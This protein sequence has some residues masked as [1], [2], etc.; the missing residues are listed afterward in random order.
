M[1]RRINKLTNSK[2]GRITRFISMLHPKNVD[3]IGSEFNFKYGDRERFQTGVGGFLTLLVVIVT[4]GAFYSTVQSLIIDPK[5]EVSVS[6]K[7]SNR[8]PRYNLYNESITLGLAFVDPLVGVQFPQNAPKYMTIKAY[9]ENLN[10]DANTALPLRRRV[11][12][13]KYKPCSQVKDKKALEPFLKHKQSKEL[14]MTF[15]FCPELDGIS[16]RYFIESKF[17][18]P[19]LYELFVYIY[20]CSLP[21]QA[22]CATPEQVSRSRM[23]YTNVRK[24][25]DP[26]NFTSPVS[27]IPEFD[28]IIQIDP[29]STK[30]LYHSVKYNEIWDDNMDFFDA[31]LRTKYADY[32]LNFKDN[33]IRNPSQF[34]CTKEM[35]ENQN[36]NLSC[37]PYI[38]FSWQSTGQTQVIKRTYSKFFESLGEVG[39]TSEILTLFVVLL[40]TGYNSYFVDRYMKRELYMKQDG[41]QSK[42]IDIFQNSGSSEQ[43]GLV[44][45]ASGEQEVAIQPLKGTFTLGRKGASSKKKKATKAEDNEKRL[46]MKAIRQNIDANEDGMQLYKKLNRFEVL[47]KILFEEHDK[48]LMPVVLLNILKNKE[49]EKEDFDEEAQSSRR[50]LS[51]RSTGTAFRSQRSLGG[52]HRP[53]GDPPDEMSVEEAYE[54]LLNHNP[55]SEIKRLIQGFILNN[56]PLGVKKPSKSAKNLDI[57][58]AFNPVTEGISNNNAL[59]T[60]PYPGYAKPGLTL[61]TFP[62]TESDNMITNPKDSVTRLDAFSSKIQLQKEKNTAEKIGQRGRGWGGGQRGQGWGGGQPKFARK[63]SKIRVRAPAARDRLNGSPRQSRSAFRS[64]I[65]DGFQI[66]KVEELS[67]IGEEQ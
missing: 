62:E 11:T 32:T 61:P 7:Y 58:A 9:I 14:A 13:V 66:L 6:T 67:Q 44:D 21:N 37:Q 43:Q 31:K 52:S 53:S 27:I 47:E 64:Q 49:K 45:G 35:I 30:Y 38:E 65:D 15:G 48:V 10:V 28:G 23:Y 17:Q 4:L 46:V 29:R 39:G 42:L 63:R 5:P 19:P 33:S 22:D 20:P 50:T 40:Y 24:L 25:V 57:V 56:L 60:G 26:D 51:A 34:Y 2:P 16:E 55:D 54:S 1:T 3:M 18:D 36:K 41:G 12:E 59:Q 8:A